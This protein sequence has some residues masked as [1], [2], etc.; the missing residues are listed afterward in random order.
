[1][2]QPTS[3]SASTTA[4]TQF[5]ATVPQSTI[6]SASR[7]QWCQWVSGQRED[8]AQDSWRQAATGHWAVGAKWWI[9]NTET[10]E[11]WT[12]RTLLWRPQPAFV[13]TLFM[14]KGCSS[15]GFIWI[16]K[17]STDTCYK[18]IL[19]I[20]VYRDSTVIIHSPLDESLVITNY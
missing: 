12:V 3:T 15:N 11:Q 14:T 7:D 4:T 5:R 1:M 19:N 6:A 13:P 18:C 16:H 20:F 10:S 9:Q 2:P 8:P 17:N